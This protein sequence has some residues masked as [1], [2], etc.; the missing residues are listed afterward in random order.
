[1]NKDI[2]I[3]Q[4][5]RR[6]LIE[7]IIFGLF[8]IA[9]IGSWMH[10]R[11][12]DG[13]AFILV[14]GKPVVCLS[15]EKEAYEV[16]QG[17]KSGQPCNPSEI[18]FKEDVVVARAPRDARPVSRH[19]AMGTVRNA[20][21]PVVPKWA[22]IVNGKP[23]VAVPSRTDAGEVLELAK[24]KFGKLARS[25]CEEPQFKEKVAVDIAAVPPSIFCKTPQEAL[26]F[27]FKTQKTES[28]DAVYIVKRGDLA[29]KIAAR[30]NLTLRELWALNPGVNLNR[31]QIGDRIRVKHTMSSTPKLTVVV[32]DQSERIETIPPPVHKISSAN[33]YLGK[34][35]EISPGKSGK[36]KVKIATVYENGRKVGSE[37]IEEEILMEPI[38]RRIVEGIKPR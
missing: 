11:F 27:I 5:K 18:E 34:T 35:A 28:Q 12:S 19:R 26:D 30:F 15:S 36:R 32:R 13:K 25:L 10:G 8:F 3:F 33:M 38:P 20:L 4:L 6:L 23:I 17:L 29:G 1:M 2:Q 22:I 9:T 31:L 21:S 14:N 37:I 24:L 7:R 16:L